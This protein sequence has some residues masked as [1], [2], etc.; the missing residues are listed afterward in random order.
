MG[1]ADGRLE[2]LA[3]GGNEDEGEGL[4]IGRGDAVGVGDGDGAASTSKVYES[5]AISL[6]SVE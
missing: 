5:R 2:G 1:D 6:S 4:M 3:L